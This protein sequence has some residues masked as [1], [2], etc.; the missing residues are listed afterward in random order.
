MD[1]MQIRATKPQ[2]RLPLTLGSFPLPLSVEIHTLYARPLQIPMKPSPANTG[3]QLPAPTLSV[4]STPGY[5]N[6]LMF[7]YILV[8][9]CL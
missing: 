7:K 4:Y 6:I 9:L 5:T 3:P 8:F 1:A 2:L